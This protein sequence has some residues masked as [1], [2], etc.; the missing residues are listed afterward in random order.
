MTTQ[1]K[2]KSV[3]QGHGNVNEEV[4]KDIIFY[5]GR[6]LNRTWLL[7]DVRQEKVVE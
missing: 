7:T 2:E 5:C 1:V 3:I 4:K 6:G